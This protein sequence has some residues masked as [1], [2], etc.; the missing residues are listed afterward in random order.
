MG[1]PMF[2]TDLVIGLVSLAF[3][4]T[5]FLAWILVIR[6]RK[7]IL[8]RFYLA[9]SFA[10]FGSGFL[11]QAVSTHDWMWWAATTAAFIVMLYYGFQYYTTWYRKWGRP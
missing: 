6:A 7:P 3:F 9:T 4:I 5:A 8:V 10:L 1:V 11:L 2:S